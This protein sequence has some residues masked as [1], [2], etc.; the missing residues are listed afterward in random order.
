[1]AIPRIIHQMWK[2]DRVPRELQSGVASWKALNPGW[3]YRFWTDRSLLEFVSDWY[4]G[5]LPVYVGYRDAIR[6]SDAARY[7]LLDHFGG[8]YADLDTE[9]LRPFEELVPENR[10][11]LC[12]EPPSQWHVQASHGA[13]PF[14]LFNGLMAGPPGHP[15]WR[16]LVERLPACRHASGVLDATGPCF[17]TGVYLWSEHR[18]RVAVH[19]ATLFSPRDWNGEPVSPYGEPRLPSL[20]DHRW[21]GSWV[22][23]RASEHLL[24]AKLALARAHLRERRSASLPS[25]DPAAA[26]AAVDREALERPPPRGENLAIMVLVRDAIAHLD[27]LVALLASLDHPTRKTKLVFVEGDSHDCSHE[28]LQALAEAARPRYRAVVVERYQSGMRHRRSER[29]LPGLQRRLRGALAAARNHAIDAGLDETDD[30]ALWL[31]PEVWK[32][33]ADLFQT[34]RA[35]GARIVVPDCTLIPGGRSVDMSTFV[36]ATPPSRESLA[37]RTFDGVFQPEGRGKSRLYLDCL[38]HSDRIDLTSVGGN[39]LLVDA[40]LHRGGLRFPEI[41]YRLHL[42]TEGFALL[43]GDLGIIPV[44]LP[45]VEVLRA[46]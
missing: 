44:G 39:V 20:A 27:G 41:P 7:L 45:R 46:P 19:P 38:R 9:C 10:V 15:F 2:D 36:Q 4:P 40:S 13:R 35:T 31:A 18:D 30:W 14:V 3:E 1:M 23:P 22:R 6:R 43:A 5:V 25:L 24:K 32:V 34:L 37:L 17:L 21:A 8:V 26:Q 29:H 11:V 12:H 28:R 42:D 33:Q 16:E